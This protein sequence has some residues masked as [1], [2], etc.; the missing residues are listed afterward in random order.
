MDSEN[1]RNTFLSLVMI[2]VVLL[3]FGM[4]GI[5]TSD[6]VSLASG[7]Q[8]LYCAN[9]TPTSLAKDQASGV[10]QSD[11]EPSPSQGT[12]T[13]SSS[14]SISLQVIPAKKQSLMAPTEES[15]ILPP[16]IAAVSSQA[17]VFQEPDPPQII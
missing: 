5:S 6:S 14:C 15:L 2:V 3:S 13:V 9:T 11:Q 1:S 10:A 4:E 16:Y 12:A 17:F 7:K 8:S